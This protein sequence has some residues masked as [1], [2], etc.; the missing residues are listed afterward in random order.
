MPGYDKLRPVALAREESILTKWVLLAI[1]VFVPA[2]TLAQVYDV[3]DLS[4]TGASSNRTDFVILGDGYRVEDQAQLTSD[5][6]TMLNGLL[7]CVSIWR[8]SQL[9]QHQ[10]SARHIQ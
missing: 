3:E 9:F 5:A 10:I 1:S 4:V 6:T 8:V 2:V 7:G